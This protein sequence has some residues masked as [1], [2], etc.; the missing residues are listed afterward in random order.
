MP[1]RHFRECH[2]D[3]L[4]LSEAKCSSRYL[5]CSTGKPNEPISN[6]G[7]IS[8]LILSGYPRFSVVFAGTKKGP[9]GPFSTTYRL[10][11]NSVDL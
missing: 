6:S 2:G 1:N 5:P 9:F 7:L 10:P 3:L 11:W 4:N 8:G